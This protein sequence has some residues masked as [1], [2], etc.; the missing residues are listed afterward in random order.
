MAISSTSR[1]WGGLRLEPYDPQARDADG[2]GIIQEGT[3]W[4]RPAGTTLLDSGGNAIP[5][6]ANSATRLAGLR[7]VDRQGREVQYTPSYEG[8]GAGAAGTALGEHGA[9]SIGERGLPTV[10]DYVTPPETPQPAAVLPSAETESENTEADDL[11]ALVEEMLEERAPEDGSSV[12]R[13]DAEVPNRDRLPYIV[14]LRGSAEP[15]DGP[16][17]AEEE[18]E[19][20]TARRRRW[21]R[22]V[23]QDELARSI[24]E[25]IRSHFRNF[26][27]RDAER[28]IDLWLDEPET[29]RI[30]SLAIQDTLDAYEDRDLLVA[31]QDATAIEILKSGRFKTQHETGTTGGLLDPEVRVE[32]EERTLGVPKDID[33]RRRPIYG[34]IRKQ[35]RRAG[36]EAEDMSATSS[37]YGRINF[38]LRKELKG[39]TTVTFGDSLG[40]DRIGVPLLSK[41]RK[42][43]ASAWYEAQAANSAI[44]AALRTEDEYHASW[45]I[46]AIGS[47]EFPDQVRSRVTARAIQEHPELASVLGEPEDFSGGGLGQYIETQIHGGVDVRDIEAIEVPS[48]VANEVRKEIERLAEPYGIKVGTRQELDGSWRKAQRRGEREK[49]EAESTPEAPTPP[50]GMSAEEIESK[51]KEIIDE[52]ATLGGIIG[53]PTAEFEFYKLEPEGSPERAVGVLTTTTERAEQRRAAMKQTL[54]GLKV[55]LETGDAKE[56][57]RVGNWDE[58]IWMS[59][60]VDHVFAEGCTVDD[61]AMMS[62]ELKTMILDMDEDELVEI[63]EEEIADFGAGYQE[64]DIGM[65]AP[66]EAL[67]DIL[68]GGQYKTIAVIEDEK[69]ETEGDAYIPEQQSLIDLRERMESMI[70]FPKSAPSDLRPA[71]TYLLHPEL[72][73]EE[74]RRAAQRL[75][76]INRDLVAQG[77]DPLPDSAVDLLPIDQAV[78][79]HVGMYGDVQFV[80]RP[81]VRGRSSIIRGD[82]LPSKG[83]A[84]PIDAGDVDI[85]NA[86]INYQ[87]EN[88]TGQRIV[89]R[90]LNALDSRRT[91][92]SVKMMGQRGY[93]DGDVASSEYM[94]AYVAGSFDMREVAEIQVNWDSLNVM[95]IRADGTSKYGIDR[96]REFLIDGGLSP[97][98]ADALVNG[99]YYTDRDQVSNQQQLNAVAGLEE[100]LE[101][102][103][104]YG[105]SVKVKLPKSGSIDSE[106]LEVLAEREVDVARLRRII[107]SRI[108]EQ[109]RA[110]D[111]ANQAA[112]ESD[113]W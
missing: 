111:A 38:R 6:G 26:P 32:F 83:G 40:E 106:L 77:Y 53:R 16:R 64:A 58:R 107:I 82:A 108:I 24:E 72:K 14:G 92:S 9:L 12:S 96:F 33:V 78:H 112:R 86:M 54:Q 20:S 10:R 100:L 47:Y 42:E 15:E 11:E 27:D 74:R 93:Q 69:R 102:A 30:V 36:L 37:F 8:A 65:A 110:T 68:A 101:S 51:N 3:A 17:P 43:I 98:E 70:G 79:G 81:E 95:G 88:K 46:D 31:A 35:S 61:Y 39:R 21:Q 28:K 90:M 52:L 18:V 44:V 103:Q 94:E 75:K 48:E 66:S 49:T 89:A 91:G 1:R 22:Y 73:E 4:E 99:S 113:N 25:R 59:G 29:K 55:F 80:L 104:S 57:A 87:Y 60:E 34:W 5:A 84:V 23:D 41:D 67:L 56:A 76:Q 45:I 13:I 19:G 71:S 2:D 63:I 85:V 50:R 109:A 97:A 105:I 62:D 7:I